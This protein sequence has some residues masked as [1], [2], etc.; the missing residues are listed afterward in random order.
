MLLLPRGRISTSFRLNWYV[1]LE[2]LYWIAGKG[3]IISNA[4]SFVTARVRTTEAARSIPMFTTT[5]SLL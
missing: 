1:S 2:A 3:D 4:I 5:N